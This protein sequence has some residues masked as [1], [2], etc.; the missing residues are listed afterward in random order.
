MKGIS[1]SIETR[2]KIGL[3]NAKDRAILDQKVEEY[4]HQLSKGD[5]PD[6]TDVALYA[7]I[8]EK[9]LLIY[10]AQT[11]QDSKIRLL[12]DHVRDLA[13]S[14]LKHGGLTKKFDGRMTA[15]LLN[16]DH[17]MKEQ[18]TTLTQ[19]NNFNISPEL[20]SEAIELSRKKKAL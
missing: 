8:A 5:F 14:A 17:G 6:I 20:L 3:A 2:Q 10:E 15:L 9:N 11:P 13:K 1:H 7:G 12:L 18:P 16:I 4:I 19:N